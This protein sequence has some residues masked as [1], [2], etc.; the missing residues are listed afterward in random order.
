MAAVFFDPTRPVYSGKD[1]F[2]GYFEWLNTDGTL[3]TLAGRNPLGILNSR[4]DVSNVN[5]HIA[6]AIV[7]YKFH[8]FPDLHLNMNVA[9]DRASTDGYQQKDSA[10]AT[11]YAVGGTNN[12]YK[13]TRTSKTFES[14]LN[15][16]KEV[17]GFRADV[18]VGYGYQ[19]SY[20]SGKNTYYNLKNQPI[21]DTVPSK[22]LP[23]NQ[24]T[25]ISF[26]GRANFG[27]KDRYLLT[28]TVV[29]MVLR[30]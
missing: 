10:A 14:Y 20:F 26:F 23:I 21:G 7:D 4:T 12:T 5:R 28:F 19:D 29:V 17:K 8:F 22:L 16:I 24:A 30:D 9:V 2:Q 18:M 6:N 27:F 25:L 13:G 3:N 1:R 11:A 15:Y